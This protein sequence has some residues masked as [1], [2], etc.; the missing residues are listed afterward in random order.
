M[1]RSL[2]FGDN[3]VLGLL[4][5]VLD[6]LQQFNG[7]LLDLTVLDIVVGQYG[8]QQPLDLA[9]KTNLL[10]NNVYKFLEDVANGYRIQCIS[11]LRHF[12]H[13][14]EDLVKESL[15]TLPPGNR[16]RNDLITILKT[17]RE[18]TNMNDVLFGILG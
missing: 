6:D 3:F 12:H 16:N 10:P 7:R 18:A 2:L 15:K 8:L 14:I 1:D 17:L 11:V 9:W 5:M 13:K 4:R